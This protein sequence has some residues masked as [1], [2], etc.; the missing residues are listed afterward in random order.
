MLQT[1]SDTTVKAAL[2]AIESESVNVVEKIQMLIEMANGL[3]QKPKDPK[4]LLS[5][6]HI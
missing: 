5:L 1:I 4:Q 3:Q 2:N 6:I